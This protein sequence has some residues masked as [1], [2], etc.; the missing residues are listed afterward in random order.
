MNKVLLL[1]TA[2]IGVSVLLSTAHAEGIRSNM[3]IYPNAQETSSLAGAAQLMPRTSEDAEQLAT[4]LL[5]FAHD[6]KEKFLAIAPGD[7]TFENTVRAFDSF[8]GAFGYRM[9]VLSS[10]KMLS[11]EMTVDEGEVFDRRTKPYMRVAQEASDLFT[12]RA[13]YNAF[14]AYRDNRF[15][16]EEARLTEEEREFFHETMS[17]FQRG[18]YEL[19]DDKFEQMKVLNKELSEL[20]AKFAGAISKDHSY[21][22]V[23]KQHLIDTGVNPEFVDACEV[24]VNEDGVEECKV[25]CNPPAL[26]AIMNGCSDSAVRRDWLRGWNRRGYP[27]NDTTLSLVLKKRLQLAQLLGYKSYA[28]MSLCNLMVGSEKAALSFVHDLKDSAIEKALQEHELF[29]QHLPEGVVLD[30]HGRLHESDKGYVIAQYERARG[31]DED[32]VAKYFPLTSTI[33]GVFDIY[34]RFMGVSFEYHSS[35]SDEERGGWHPDTQAITVRTRD[36]SRVLGHIFLDLFPRPGKY[37]HFCCAPYQPSFRDGYYCP[38]TGEYEHP[39]AVGGVIGNFPEPT[40]D[41]DALLKHREVQTFF[42]EFGHAMHFV[43]G[44]SSFFETT[45][46]DVKWDFVELPSQILEEWLWDTEVVQGLSSYYRDEP[47]G[48]RKKG[49]RIPTETIAAMVDL[50]RAKS[51]LF[52][53]RQLHYSQ[54]SLDYY[55]DSDEKEAADL[56]RLMKRN[57]E[58]FQPMISSDDENRHYASFGHLMGYGPR[59]YGYMY[60]RAYAED[61]LNKIKE[62]GAARGENGL[63]ADYE[64]DQDGNPLSAGAYFVHHILKPGGSVHPHK[65][66]ENMLGRPASLDAFCKKMLG[67]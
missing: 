67:K 3:S 21:I 5:A 33:H 65:L 44:A 36:R 7:R 14:V 61:V 42:H 37:T 58:L 30:E 19:A 57:G 32:E 51:G 62:I 64:V 66:L 24:I 9:A 28:E 25:L 35:L 10:F 49:D 12:D 55:N 15:A 56:Y 63:L 20:S 16:E 27:E 13:I 38:E 41:R 29:S 4:D 59:Y 40:K 43:L 39:V 11:D 60:S 48:S 53:V 18:G 1:R 6:Q 34:E 54:L 23:A 46:I 31:V 22:M 2:L 26:S 47:D 45:G 8:S 17:D 50:D 52:L